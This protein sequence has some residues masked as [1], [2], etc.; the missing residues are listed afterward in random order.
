MN[1]NE[2]FVVG[3]MSGTSLDGVDLVYVKFSNKKTKI[4][5]FYMHKLLGIQKNGNRDCKMPL[6][7]LQM[8]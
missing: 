6:I 5:I 7:F 3:V 1:T 2:V 8:I 4:L